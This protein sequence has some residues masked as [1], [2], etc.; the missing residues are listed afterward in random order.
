MLQMMM[1]IIATPGMGAGA[2]ADLRRAPVAAVSR[3][4]GLRTDSARVDFTHRIA[5]SAAPVLGKPAADPAETGH[6]RR[7]WRL[8]ESGGQ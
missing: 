6:P 3:R 2:H 7:T 5:E 1:E 8:K 4:F